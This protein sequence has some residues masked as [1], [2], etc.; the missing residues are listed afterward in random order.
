M[1]LDKKGMTLFLIREIRGLEQG[2]TVDTLADGLV[3]ERLVTAYFVD[4]DIVLLLEV[5]VLAVHQPQQNNDQ[6]RQHR[7]DADQHEDDCGCLHNLCAF[8]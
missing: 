6:C 5:L 4:D 1:K 3:D 8:S 7:Y 2:G